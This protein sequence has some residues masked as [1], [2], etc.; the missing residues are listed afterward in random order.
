MTIIVF[1][2]DKRKKP[3]RKPSTP[4]M[5]LK[6]GKCW[7]NKKLRQI[8]KSTACGHQNRLKTC[9]ILL[10]IFHQ[11]NTVLKPPRRKRGDKPSFVTIAGK[12]D[13][14]T[15]MLPNWYSNDVFGE[16]QVVATNLFVSK[17]HPTVPSRIVIS[18]QIPRIVSISTHSPIPKDPIT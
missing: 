6:F 8:H 18:V 10:F 2:V 4:S 3:S 12:G 9:T 1:F 14:T 7:M 13:N 11:A 16:K 5:F 15:H 17:H